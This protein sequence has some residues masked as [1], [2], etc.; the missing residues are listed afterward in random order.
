MTIRTLEPIIREHPF[1][2]GLPD[3]YLSLI[4]GCARNERFEDGQVLFHE[5]EEADQFFVIRQGQVALEIHVPGR[6]PARL[7]TVA[8][9]EV[10]GWSW[11]FPPY[12]WQL[13]ARALGSVRAIAFDGKCL[14]AKCEES[15]DLGYELMKRFAQV[16]MQRLSATRLQLLD[17]Y[18]THA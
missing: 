4:V 12:R 7:E 11:L 6:G 17:L 15:H 2:R 14:R 10:V 3:P 16:V 13:T 5:A 1:F 8:D 18:A 9:G